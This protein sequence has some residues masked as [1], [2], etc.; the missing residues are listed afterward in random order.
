MKLFEIVCILFLLILCSITDI[1]ERKIY[2]EVCIIFMLIGVILEFII[3]QRN[4]LDICLGILPGIFIYMVFIVTREGIGKGDAMV[5]IT[6][7]VF[8]GI[9]NSIFLLIFSLILVGITAFIIIIL[10]KGNK[11]TK[12]PFVPFVTIS[13]II[14]ACTT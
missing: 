11:K 12:I 6:T 10:K 1:K 5:F 14:F 13:F 9:I 3:R 2:A 4:L 8:M 7:G